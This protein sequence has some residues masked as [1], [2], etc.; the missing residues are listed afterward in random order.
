MAKWYSESQLIGA[1]GE[2]LVELR[3][4]EMGFLYNPTKM[5]A[6]IDGEIEIRDPV[7]GEVTGQIVRVQSKASNNAFPKETDE[8]FE[9]TC[10]KKDLE[11]W[12]SADNNPILLVVSRPR[13]HEAYWICVQDHFNTAEKRKA[14]K[15]WFN[16]EEDRFDESARDRIIQ[17]GRDRKSG[18]YINPA[19]RQETLYSNLLE[20]IRIPKFIY[21]AETTL[22]TP[23]QVIGKA[24]EMDIWL[25][26]GWA[27]WEGRLWSAYDLSEA[28]WPS[29]C[30]ANTIEPIEGE[31]WA[32]SKIQD[33]INLFI[34]VLKGCLE[35]FLWDRGVRY[36]RN[37]RHYHFKSPKHPKPKEVPYRTH[38]GRASSITVIVKREYESKGETWSY[39]QH[40]AFEAI[41][42][43]LGG[44]WYL[45]ITPTYRYTWDGHNLDPL[46]ES[47]L[48]WMKKTEKN[49]AVLS[50]V[51]LWAYTLSKSKGMFDY[52][53][54]GFGQRLTVEMPVGINDAVWKAKEE[55]D[56]ALE[57]AKRGAQLEIVFQSSHQEVK[58]EG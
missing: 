53:H 16:K 8:G 21:S 2:S 57:K 45:R 17:L 28:P 33:Q 27:T 32:S 38:K 37:M 52:P 31:E 29:L 22:R 46:Y 4:L 20:I 47:H 36:D 40:H 15:V 12:L 34:R 54:L 26:R 49:R 56:K 19:P 14:R 24:R 44:V 13:T 6:G 42:L 1:R 39:Y 58:H 23:G 18:L 9:F 11:Y 5:D 55:E 43:R 41:F 30:D 51:D 50:G 25:K 48:S 3:V 7:T 10:L 35:D